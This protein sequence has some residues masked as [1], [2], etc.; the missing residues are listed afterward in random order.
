MTGNKSVRILFILCAIAVPIASR[1]DTTSIGPSGELLLDATLRSDGTRKRRETLSSLASLLGTS[2]LSADD[3][4][5][6]RQKG[7]KDRMGNMVN[8]HIKN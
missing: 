4:I 3:S 1:R 2:T 5:Q 8:E 6:D 7:V